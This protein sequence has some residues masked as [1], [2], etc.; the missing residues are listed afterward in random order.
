M[1]KKPHTKCI[2][3][4][5]KAN[6]MDY[7]FG[8]KY[9]GIF[10]GLLEVQSRWTRGNSRAYVPEVLTGFETKMCVKMLIT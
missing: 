4:Y 8:Y 2:I 3:G 10:C 6:D 1:S 9:M 5:N 7:D